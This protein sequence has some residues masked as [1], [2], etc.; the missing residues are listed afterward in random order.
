MGC[1]NPDTTLLLGAGRKAIL[2]TSAAQWG[3]AMV[4][5]HR[6]EVRVAGTSYLMPAA[7]QTKGPLVHERKGYSAQDANRH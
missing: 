3:V 1:D 6:Q 4:R 2:V 7:K 5:V